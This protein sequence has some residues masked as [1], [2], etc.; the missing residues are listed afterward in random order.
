ML[1]YILSKDGKNEDKR[2]INAYSVLLD[3]T[4]ALKVFKPL[5]HLLNSLKSGI[6]HL[7]DATLAKIAAA[8]PSI[9]DLQKV[10]FIP[11][12]GRKVRAICLADWLTQLSVLPIADLLFQVLDNHP[13]DCRKN[14][15]KG[16]AYVR[17]VYERHESVQSID[18][19]DI[20][21]R[22][23]LT[24][25]LLLIQKILVYAGVGLNSSQ[26][27]CNALSVILGPNRNYQ[28][29]IIGYI[30]YK[31]GQPMGNLLS[32]PLATL[33][34][35]YMVILSAYIA[36]YPEKLAG[37]KSKLNDNYTFDEY[38]ILGD[39]LVVGDYPTAQAYLT[40][41]RAL[42]MEISIAKSFGMDTIRSSQH[43]HLSEFAKR[44]TLR[45]SVSWLDITPL[46]PLVLS[47]SLVKAIIDL[48]RK[49]DT[50][51]KDV[52]VTWSR[53][54]LCSNAVK[55]TYKR[56]LAYICLIISLPTTLVTQGVHS[57]ILSIRELPS[58]LSDAYGK[59]MEKMHSNSFI[60]KKKAIMHIL[61]DSTLPTKG[62]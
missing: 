18:S 32:F 2:L 45:T 30:A 44:L 25:Q 46:S 14:Q 33:T 24:L 16:V 43:S 36:H 12:K 8:T 15:S 5:H 35:H 13:N 52:V 3:I 61:K 40:V 37:V 4:R 6:A 17:K 11:D 23:P 51:L 9:D 57:T 55:F 19:K 7:S 28:T 60:T 1:R 10:Q 53:V 49:D 48:V 21:D 31:V 62:R 56:L 27:I 26:K 58:D 50:L 41:S 47:E 34:H 54:T 38:A 42:G 20:T 22:L 29:D 59:A 39:D